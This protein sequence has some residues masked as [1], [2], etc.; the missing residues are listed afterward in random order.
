MIEK[1]VRAPCLIKGLLPECWIFTGA[2]LK[3]YGQIHSEGRT[4]Y[5]HQIAYAEMIGDMPEGLEP[6][7]LCGRTDCWNPWHLDPV[8]H[9]INVARGP[10]GKHQARKTHCPAGHP[11]SEENTYQHPGRNNRLCRTCRKEDA[12]VRYHA[13]KEKI[14]ARRARK[15][16]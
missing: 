8:T 6:D 5:T 3:G 12:L 16:V 11:Y 13:N 2:K 9:R 1:S 10:W 14:N 7:H 4:E 15:N